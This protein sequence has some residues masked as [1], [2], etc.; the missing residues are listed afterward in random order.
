ME[1]LAGDDENPAHPWVRP[2]GGCRALHNERRHQRSPLRRVRDVLIHPRGLVRGH[3]QR[4]RLPG[5][6]GGR[7]GRVRAA[8][9]VRARPR[10]FRRRS[11][12]P[13]RAISATR[14]RTSCR[15][16][17]N[18]SYGDPQTVQVNARRDLGKITVKYTINSGRERSASTREWQGGLRYGDVGD[19]YYHRLRG[20]VRGA[21]PGDV[22]RG[23]VRRRQRARRQRAARSATRWRRTRTRGCSCSPRRTTPA[24]RRSRRITNTTSPNFL[25]YYTEA[26]GQRVRHDVY[27]YDAQR[28]QGAGPARSA[29]PLRRGDLVHGQRQRRPAP[30]P[31]AR[32]GGAGGTPLDHR[33]ARLRQRGRASGAHG[34]QRRPPMGSRRVPAGGLPGVTVRR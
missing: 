5:R 21:D 25:S 7:P 16:R 3:R 32:R 4:L 23:L 29:E 26:L 28:P 33:G 10:P 13:G 8:R 6:G 9:A 24:T 2:G 22:V 1:A 11:L 30:A 14:R 18:V 17:F 34:R 27:D 19:I 12:E 31:T 15:T 20:E